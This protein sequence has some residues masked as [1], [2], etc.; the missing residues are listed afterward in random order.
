MGFSYKPQRQLIWAQKEV[1]QAY[2]VAYNVSE[3]IGEIELR[4][5]WEKG[6][7]GSSP[8]HRNIWTTE[9]TP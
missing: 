5:K 6:K 2:C 7:L 8:N 4:E 3:K 1:I 9:K